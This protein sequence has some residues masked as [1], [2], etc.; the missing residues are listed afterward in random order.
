M[1]IL[2]GTRGIM[3][4]VEKFMRD[5]SA[6]MLPFEYGADPRRQR[7]AQDMALQVR[8]SPIQLWDISFPMECKDMML[9]TLFPNGAKGMG[10]NRQVAALGLRTLMGFDKMPE[11]WDTSKHIALPTSPNNI[12]MIGIGMKPDVLL[13]AKTPLIEQI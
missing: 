9:T 12:E 11:K 3:H 8:I 10:M 7:G 2:L 13:P 1:H 4:D 6:Q 5:L